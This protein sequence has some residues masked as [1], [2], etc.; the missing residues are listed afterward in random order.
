MIGRLDGA[1]FGVGHS[2]AGPSSVI[3]VYHFGD[4]PLP[5]TV[6]AF[7]QGNDEGVTE[8][9]AVRIAGFA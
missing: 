1:G 2:G 4:R 9:E 8:H 3:A 6:A 7:A 5:C